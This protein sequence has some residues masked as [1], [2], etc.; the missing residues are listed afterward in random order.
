MILPPNTVKFS[1]IPRASS[2]GYPDDEIAPGKFVDTSP[3]DVSTLYQAADIIDRK[4][5]EVYGL[6]RTLRAAAYE[7][8]QLRKALAEAR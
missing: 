2:A 4:P 8:E 1:D 7:I 5:C 3:F 6:N